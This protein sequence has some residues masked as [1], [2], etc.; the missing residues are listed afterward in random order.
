MTSPTRKERVMEKRPEKYEDSIYTYNMAGA[1]L[2]VIPCADPVTWVAGLSE[3]GAPKDCSATVWTWGPS[4]PGNV[5]G[6]VHVLGPRLA[7][8][9]AANT[10]YDLMK[11]MGVL[12]SNPHI[13][14]A[15]GIHGMIDRDP[16]LQQALLDGLSVWKQLGNTLALLVP[17][18]T[19][20]TGFL[21]VYA[22]SLEVPLPDADTLEA[23]AANLKRENNLKGEV[24]GLGK[25]LLGV[26]AFQAE[27]GLARLSIRL[28]R[29]PTPEEAGTIKA[30]AINSHP[31]LEYVPPE[32]LPKWEEVEGLGNLKNFMYQTS[33]SPISKGVMI[34]GPAGTGKT[35]SAKALAG[36]LG[37]PLVMFNLS[38]VFGG[39]VGQ[40]EA[41]VR[42]ALSILKRIG[43]H[44]LVLDEIEK[45]IG[46]AVQSGR[47]DG[48]VG[49]R[50]A[51]ELL[52][53]LQDRPEGIY[54]C[55]TCFHGDTLVLGDGGS[56]IPIIRVQD[57]ESFEA[58]TLNPAT[59][60]PTFDAPQRVFVGDTAEG[61]EV[62]ASASVTKCTPGHLFF[63]F[64][65]SGLAEVRAED[66]TPGGF[67]ASPRI[68]PQ[69]TEALDSDLSYL[70]GYTVGDGGVATS[71]TTIGP[72]RLQWAE[73]DMGQIAYISTLCGKVFGKV[74][75]VCKRKRVK[76]SVI[77]LDS[78][79][80]VQGFLSDF[81]F[82]VGPSTR[83][84]VPQRI[85]E[86]DNPSVA[87]FLSGLYDA[88]GTVG[89]TGVIGFTTVSPILAHQ[90]TLLLRRFGLQGTMSK[91]NKKPNPAYTVT[92][93]G[94]EARNFSRMI[95]FRMKRKQDK[96]GA[97][98]T[99]VKKGP[100][101]DSVPVSWGALKALGHYTDTWGLN[102][103]K[104][105]PRAR[106]EAGI[107]KLQGF[108]V[109]TSSVDWVLSYCW[110]RV[111]KVTPCEGFPVYDLTMSTH[112]T[113]TANGVMV[114]N[115]NNMEA[116]PPEY[117][118]AERFDAIF[119]VDLPTVD[120]R[121]AILAL[122]AK[123]YGV[124]VEGV[125][126]ETTLEG[127][128]GAEIQ[129]LC[130]IA[131]MMKTSAKEAVQFVVP[132]SRTMKEKIDTLRD[133]S[134]GRCVPASSPIP[135][136]PE[137]PKPPEG[138]KARKLGGLVN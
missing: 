87:A 50:V 76:G 83:R 71:P 131:S 65:P 128:T 25:A 58:L 119:F 4:G 36:A 18:G 89:K 41:A 107:K 11:V 109:D 98:K 75:G 16:A 113:Y 47:S 78:T 28:K 77:Y 95:G 29:L 82:G 27:D 137:A 19:Q 69:G 110:Q 108:G 13:V 21:G 74:A 62:S 102:R 86:S 32:L 104:T 99:A 37:C 48:G 80:K 92:L 42:M 122:Y 112:H 66:L 91:W 31:A 124:K 34:L 33:S 133:W 67:L 79:Q 22:E 123:K 3:K 30:G 59:G 39:L 26:T 111:K 81:S 5:R 114:H 61:V 106:F 14:L 117:T 17:T 64:S 68:L 35:M 103:T 127:W 120:E 2:M 52:L 60:Q 6:L 90:V 12:N 96:A 46:G 70:V 63:T 105:I 72:H 126:V 7:Q 24:A 94:E 101:I 43:P 130:R 129:S 56:I 138:L 38:A 97:I 53:F 84:E 55:A 44:V 8:V 100:A 49:E 118:R 125:S 51:K 57:A 73:Q 134:V 1:P 116:L 136:V 9:P 115:C 40:S 88:D 135:I 85:C 20:L 10:P 15:Y 121:K 54:V 23:I 93:S 45:L 132:I